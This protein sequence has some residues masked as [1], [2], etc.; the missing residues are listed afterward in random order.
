MSIK[1]P[2]FLVNVLRCF[3]IKIL[4]NGCIFVNFGWLF[5]KTVFSNWMVSLKVIVSYMYC[6]FVAANVSDFILNFQE[7]FSQ[8]QNISAKQILK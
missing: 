5:F 6:L 3:S 8:L 2:F 4:Y 7:N 1:M